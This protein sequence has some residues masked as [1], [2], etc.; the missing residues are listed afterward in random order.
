[1]AKQTTPTFTIELKLKTNEQEESVLDKRFRIGNHI[2]NVMVKEAK[3][4]LNNLLAD[5][6]YKEIMHNYHQTKK[7]KKGD[8]TKLKEIRELYGLTKYDF[9]NYLAKGQNQ[10]LNNIGSPIRTNIAERVWK[11]VEAFLFKKGKEIQ[12]RK[13]VM[14]KSVEAK[15]NDAEI[16]YRNGEILWKGLKMKAIIKSKDIYAYDA[17]KNHRIKYCRIKRIWKKG[18]WRY[19]VQLALEGI[20]KYKINLKFKDNRKVGIDM[21]PSSIAVVSKDKLIHQELGGNVVNIEK[22][23]KRLNRQI[24]RQRRANN[25]NNYNDDGTIKRDTKTFKK[26]WV[27][28]KRMQKV[29]SKRRELYGK[30]SRKLKQS[31][32]MLANK[33]L[34][35]CGTNIVF[36]NMNY[37]GLAKKSKETE[38]SEKTGKFKRKKRFGKSISNHAPF[39]FETILKLKLRYINKEPLKLKNKDIKASQYNHLTGEYQKAELKDRWKRLDEDIIVQRDLYSAFI[40]M[41]CIDESTIDVEECIKDFDDFKKKHDELINKLKKQKQAGKKF[42]ACMGI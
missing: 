31:H 39:K 4:R 20:P 7:F 5:K 29:E 34:T 17:I 38:I 8:K 24:D 35:E 28:S 30:R 32:E 23:I 9:V 10:Y 14:F 25:P 6:E 33:I 15:S 11:A 26:K 1:M 40:Q 13:L 2:Y 19:Y 22:T 18:K 3:R 36:E 42:P 21:G 27:K 16:L 12:F 41:H 37:Q